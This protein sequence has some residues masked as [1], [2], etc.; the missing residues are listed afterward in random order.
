MTKR[1]YRTDQVV[2]QWDSSRCIHT[3]FCLK[4]LPAVFDT[5]RRPWVDIDAADADAIAAAVE[6]CPSGALQYERLDGPGEQPDVPASTVPWPSGP[7]MVRGDVE[8]R[9]TRGELLRAGYR[10]ALC[11]CGHS[12]N[13]PFCDM[14]HVEAEFR[15]DPRG[16]LRQHP[17]A[18]RPSD[19]SEK[20]S[21]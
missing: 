18:D 12:Q 17:E 21:V 4:A 20:P 2:V 8:V 11:R 9:T 5:S 13:P 14:S 15:D 19:L 6:Q 1:S 10:M 7:L 16:S 3:G